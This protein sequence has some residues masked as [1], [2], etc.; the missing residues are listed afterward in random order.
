MTQKTKI[1]FFL[2]IRGSQTKAF[3]NFVYFTHRELKGNDNFT[4]EYII[5]VAEMHSI[6]EVK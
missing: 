5:S 3:N 6:L 1:Q 4:G 2:H